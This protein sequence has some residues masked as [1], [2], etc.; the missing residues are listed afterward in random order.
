MK[1]RRLAVPIASAISTNQ[2]EAAVD[3]CVAGLG[4]GMFLSY[5]VAPHAASKALRYVLTAFEPEPVPVHVIYPH[6]RLLSPKVRAMV[7][8]CVSALRSTR[9]D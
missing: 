4:L 8:A 2:V 9:F 6:T 5:Q 1:R 3:M 7:D